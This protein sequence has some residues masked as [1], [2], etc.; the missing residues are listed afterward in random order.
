MCAR[1]S[2][3][4]ARYEIA[5][6]LV[7]C[8]CVRVRALFSEAVVVQA[9]VEVAVE[10]PRYATATAPRCP[11]IALREG[12][13]EVERLRA[14]TRRSEVEL[15]LHALA[16]EVGGH[17][18]VPPCA[19]WDSGDSKAVFMDSRPCTCTSFLDYVVFA[20]ED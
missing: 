17:A 7:W 16:V 13:E 4:N 14:E 1:T 11:G 9:S 5:T 19:F 10:H 18:C 6:F 8:R 20:A 3:L 15:E 2:K 12:L